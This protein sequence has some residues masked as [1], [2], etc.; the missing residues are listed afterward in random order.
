VALA[1]AM[2][3]D[4]VAAQ[5]VTPEMLD[6][7]L[8]VRTVVS[9]LAAPIG[10]AFL[11]PNDM[12]VLE[13]DSGRV[14][15]VIDGAASGPVLDLGVNNASERGLL[16]IA[17]H[18]QFPSN[19][20][21]YLY[22]T[23]RSSG[24]PFDPFFPDERECLDSNMLLSDT[25]DVLE[26]PLL[27]N[28]VDRFVWNGSGLTYDRNLIML[29]AFQNDGS[30]TPE[31]QNDS[32]QPPRGNHDGG[33]I[34]FGPDGKLY[35]VIGDTGR[36]GQMQNLADGPG[37]PTRFDDQFGGPEPDDAHLTGVILRLNDDG[38][39]PEDNPF[40]AAGAAI[41]GEVGENIQ[42][43]F[44]YGLRNSF[45]MAFDPVSGALWE[46]ENGD[47][48]FSEINRVDPGFNSGWVQIMGPPE[49]IGQFK[50]IETTVTPNPPDPFAST[51]F[52]LQ[53][54]RW[55][56][57]NIADSAAE[58][59]SRLFMLPGA[60]YS[61]PE[62]SWKFEVAPGGIGFVR[63]R[64]LGPQYAGDLFI[65][66]ARPFLEGGHLFRLQLTGNRRS[67]GVDDPRL[68]DRV[69]DNLHKWEITESE[70]L[71]VGRN[72]GVGTDVQTG[73]NGNLYVVSLSDN[74]VYEI[75]RR[76]R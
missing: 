10:I 72:F 30:P 13:K 50:T 22:W 69:A 73:P 43:I 65:A 12:L 27:G 49:R 7:N 9:E 4:R 36:R 67:I 29:R 15:R 56:P 54:L 57:E 3:N 66:A 52:G 5:V 14:Q 31:G 40:F 37:G 32:D 6:R 25:N 63:G 70:S 68:D 18:P 23:C 64:A 20:G 45:G 71:L 59:L 19:P 48:S 2:A 62:F 75:S 8:R 60:H 24:P 16:G 74:A 61:A 41:D 26:V 35:I 55:S 17:L 1:V 46:Q 47:D 44:A 11:G 58:G 34:R 38:S 42:K 51:Y 28:R 53:Q 21:V 39:T 33:V 76:R